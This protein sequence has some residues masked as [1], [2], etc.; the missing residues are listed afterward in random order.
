MHPRPSLP[1]GRHGEDAGTFAAM[2]RKKSEMNKFILIFF[3]SI[4]F[5]I[6]GTSQ[7]LIG[8]KKGN[9]IYSSV[10]NKISYTGNYNCV[11]LKVKIEGFD[12]ILKLKNCEFEITHLKFDTSRLQILNEVDKTIF[13]T[14]LIKKRNEAK[15]YLKI[16]E[17]LLTKGVIQKEDLQLIDKV[18]INYSCPWLKETKVYGFN[19]IIIDEKGKHL[20]YEVNGNKIRDKDKDEILLMNKPKRIYIEQINWIPIGCFEKINSITIDIK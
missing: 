3:L 9:I 20:S 5:Q 8:G 19:F 4:L 10:T 16:G 13:D 12:E 17:K 7:I 11:K 2:K 18:E 14:V 15:A 6:N 1:F